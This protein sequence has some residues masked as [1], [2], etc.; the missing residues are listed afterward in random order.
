M[1]GFLVSNS[2]NGEQATSLTVLL[3][4]FSTPKSTLFISKIIFYLLIAIIGN[5]LTLLVIINFL[6]MYIRFDYL[7]IIFLII[8]SGIFFSTVFSLLINTI[9][10][11]NMIL[12]NLILIVSWV[13]LFMFQN[14]IENN[15]SIPSFL[16]VYIIP[17][18]VLTGFLTKGT[19]DDINLFIF[20]F[21]C[22]FFI[23]LMLFIKF[24]N[25]E[26]N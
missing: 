22:N 26:F 25:K 21:I 18:S 1:I 15:K 14:D 9:L 20:I 11:N 17:Q 12:S 5:F 7:L 4:N 16:R 8:T 6:K 10:E 19:W 13:S 24:A 2:F 3:L 23:I